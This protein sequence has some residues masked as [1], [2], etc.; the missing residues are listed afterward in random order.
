MEGMT[1]APRSLPILTALVVAGAGAPAAA[2]PCSV[3]STVT[4]VALEPRIVVAG[5]SA[6]ATVQE[7]FRG[8]GHEVAAGRDQVV[9]VRL[10]PAGS[11]DTIE[12][13]TAIDPKTRTIEIDI[14]N[15]RWVGP[16][17]ANVV[18][19]PLVEAGIGKLAAGRWTIE[20]REAVVD[21][22]ARGWARGTRKTRLRS[23][24]S[25]EVR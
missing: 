9:I 7:R 4:R 18:E 8:A 23:T 22:D 25:F 17:A 2:A 21:V 10:D 3:G 19:T 13:C 20:V 15:R 5:A 24:Y 11:A 12:A 14:V 1:L 16:L 6:G